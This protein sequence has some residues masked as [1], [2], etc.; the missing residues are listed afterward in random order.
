[1]TEKKPIQMWIEALR[2]G[3]FKQGFRNLRSGDEYCCMGVACE[4]AM[5]N[6]VKIDRQEI[7]SGRWIYDRFAGCWP[8]SVEDWLSVGPISTNVL[9]NMNDN[10]VKSFNEIADYLEKLYV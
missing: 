4:L 7:S 8:V 6:G 10:Q 9:V 5:E 2:S 3:K 1:M